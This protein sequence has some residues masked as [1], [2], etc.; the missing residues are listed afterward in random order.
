MRLKLP[1]TDPTPMTD[2][3]GGAI[4]ARFEGRRVNSLSD[5]KSRGRMTHRPLVLLGAVLTMFMVAVEATIVATALPSIVA[6]LGGFEQFSWVFAIYLLA[7]AVTVPI[8]GRL[9]DLY[10][11]KPMFFV[12]ATVF[13]AGSTACGFAHSMVALIIFRA[14]QG[15]GAGALQ[16]TI[17]TVIG[18]IYGAEGRAKAQGAISAVWGVSSIA[19]PLLGAF[20]VEHLNWPLVF[21]INLPV[22]GAAALLFGLFL[23]ENV[24]RHK[25]RID[26]PG[27]LLFAAAAAALLLALIQGAAL[28]KAVVIGLLVAAVVLGIVFFR[29]QLRVTEPMMQ[30]DLWRNRVIAISNIGA[31]SVGAIMM[32]VTLVLPIFVQGVMGQPP[33]AAGLVIGAMS[34]GWPAAT[35]VSG[36]FMTRTSYRTVALTGALILVAGSVFL[37][38]LTSERGP[39]W[40]GAGA[41]II[42]IGMGFTTI[43]YLI[44]I[45]SGVDWQQR[46]AATA[47]N[48][49][50]RM[51]GQVVGAALYGAILNYGIQRRAPDAAGMINQLI[52]PAERHKL[53]ESVV[54]HLTGVIG[55][56][57]HDVYWVSTGVAVATLLIALR[58]PAGLRPERDKKPGG[59]AG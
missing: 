33:L 40:A 7:T 11:R 53:A 26:W 58:I 41:A 8:Y 42:G 15:I 43:V 18:D 10:G 25:H 20:I 59:H 23:H 2:G 3:R 46:G 12:G 51:L 21:W 14:V 1:L 28:P 30:L 52:E 57:L 6:D 37:L 27:A 34:I 45:Q 54:D 55:A 50:M 44:S 5:R 49:F 48:V 16:P 17:F 56:S 31:L 13:L 39:V 32:G 9:A 38:F 22:G 29:Q 4:R 35:T 19:G 36:W 47:S 24:A